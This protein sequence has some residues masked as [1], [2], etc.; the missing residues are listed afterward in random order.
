MFEAFLITLI[1]VG[2]FVVFCFLL[3]RSLYDNKIAMV[4]FVFWC[5]IAVFLPTYAGMEESKRENIPAECV[6]NGKHK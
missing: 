6:M 1:I 5:A 3:T 2:Y 4:G